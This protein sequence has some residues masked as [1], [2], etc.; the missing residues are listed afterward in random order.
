MVSWIADASAAAYGLPI[1]KLIHRPA[2]AQHQHATASEVASET[3]IMQRGVRDH[4]Q[5]N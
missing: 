4:G 3:S 5:I 2:A 1:K